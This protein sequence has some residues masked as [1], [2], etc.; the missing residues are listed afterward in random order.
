MRRLVSASCSSGRRFA[1]DFLRIR[2]R[3]RHPCLWL[4]LPLAGCTKDFHL[5]VR[6]PCRAHKTNSG[7]KAAAVICQ[8]PTQLLKNSMPSRDHVPKVWF[9]SGGGIV[10]IPSLQCPTRPVFPARAPHGDSRSLHSFRYR[11]IYPQQLKQAEQLR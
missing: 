7:P 2:S 9:L 6:A 5:Q 4:V 8:V 3:P 1:S 11:Q 10:Q